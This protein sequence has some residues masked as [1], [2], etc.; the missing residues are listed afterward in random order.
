MKDKLHWH[1]AFVQAMQL[2]LFEYLDVLEFKQEHQLT[3]EPLQI[4]LIIIKKTKDV[5]IDKNIARIFKKENILEYK[6]PDDHLS[7]KDFCKVYAYANL[8]AA[9]TPG[10]DLSELTLT[11]VT[12]RYPQKLMRYLCKIR[13]YTIK[14][15]APGIYLI[16]GD[17]ISM[18]II[19]TKRLTEGENLWLG[20]LRSGLRARAVRTILQSGEKQGRGEYLSAYLNILM[21][22]NLDTFLE[23]V[24]MGKKYPTTEEMIIKICQ[25]PKYREQPLAQKILQ[26]FEQGRA[27][28]LERGLAQGIKRGMARGRTEE[29]LETA[30]NALAKGHPLEL[31]HDITGLELET[32]QSLAKHR[33]KQ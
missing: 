1:P 33:E 16:Q 32:L 23:G 28:G 2:E 6:S 5:A 11:F 20:S 27:E 14:E 24:N 12:N 17:Y 30:R 31:I 13:G 15:S 18:Q 26:G 10:A 7:V 25:L 29:R 22:S 8:Y 4:D 21:R 19:E 3:T 9:I